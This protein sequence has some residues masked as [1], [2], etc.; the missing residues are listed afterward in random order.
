M[1]RE[2]KNGGAQDANGAGSDQATVR[3][4]E[5]AEARSL[6]PPFSRI[7]S[8]ISVGFAFFQIYTGVFG[9]F[10]D[11]IQRSV[12][13][14]F[15]IALAFL[16]YRATRKSP[17]T[18][19]SRVDLLGM[20]LGAIV[21]SYAALNYDRFMTNPGI[22]N[23][24][25]LVLGVLATILVLETTRRVL[26]W[27]LPCIALLVILYAH[28]GPHLPEFI[29]HRGFRV[30]YI[31]ETLYTSTSGI[32]GSVTGVS[33]TIIASFLI[34]GSV[35]YYTGGGEVFVDLAKGI[36]GR[37]YGGPAKV[38]CISSALFGTISGSAVAN[39]VVDGVFNIPLMKKLGY[40]SEF[41][42]ATEATASTGGQLMPPVMGAGAFIMAEFLGIPYLKVAEAAL[43]P[44]LLY[45]LGVMA[46]VHFAARN[47][48][49]ERLPKEM[50]PPL[51][52]TLRRSANLFVPVG[53]LVYLMSKGFDP[54][55]SVLWAIGAS[56]G[57]H[58]LS[59]RNWSTVRDRLRDLFVAL[60]AGG[61][62]IVTVASLCACAQVVIGIVNLSGLGIRMTE[63]VLGLSGGITIIALFLT[64][65]VCLVLGMGLPTTAAYVLAA[66][67]AGPALTKLGV[68]PIAAHLFVFYFAILSAITPPVCAATYAAV[69][70]A[71]SKWLPTG[72][73]AVRMGLAG[74]ITPFLF[75]S[76]PSLLMK[77]SI[78][79]VI[80]NSLLSGIGVMAMAGASM[81]YFGDRNKAHESL[82]L[83]LGALLTLKPGLI[84][85][86]LGLA[87]VGSIYVLQRKRRSLGDKVGVLRGGEYPTRTV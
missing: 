68:T 78:L 13:V 10:P 28:L 4:P 87:M 79:E 39:V 81:G 48:N 62:S 5:Q 15:T 85:D 82:L 49:L 71:R 86:L 21:C 77:G 72:W 17:K 26:S 29:A 52:K 75:V 46:S 57:L 3:D 41:A 64:M 27:I 67:I 60:D 63:M 47:F 70:I 32:W 19:M 54:T 53:L 9:C 36:A 30:E 2:K 33:A 20:F 80:W 83:L 44:A 43:I 65:I 40:K 73:M 22:S 37:S 11:L 14:G 6:E 56:A 76:M 24:W 69:A 1:A 8:A 74:F 84:T 16:L 51:R 55:T 18:R 7:A 50:I 25:D 31:I 58:L 34:F 23:T 42:A 38:S 59:C 45:Y 35:L 61:R 12:H 66:S